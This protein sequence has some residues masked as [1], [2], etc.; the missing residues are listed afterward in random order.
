MT[1]FKQLALSFCRDQSGAVTVDW[2][3]LT[4]A[5][6]GIGIAAAA[7]VAGGVDALGTKI[8]TALGEASISVFSGSGD[9]ATTTAFSGKTAND[10]VT[11]G[12]SLAPGNNGAAYFW[13]S[14]AAS[15]DAPAGY[16]FNNPLHDPASGNVIYTSDDGS[17]YSIGGKVTAISD[18]KGKANYFGA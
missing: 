9:A 6:V 3:V 18:Y 1:R 16:N 7:S 17:S 14:G 15:K 4:A 13:A 11:Y 12:Q 8:S 10:Y 2:V 5:T